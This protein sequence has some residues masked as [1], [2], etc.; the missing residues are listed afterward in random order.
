MTSLF[1]RL[2]QKVSHTRV[3]TAT[4]SRKLRRVARRALL[5]RVGK[6]GPR[7]SLVI[8]PIQQDQRSDHG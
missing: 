3:L 4:R 7:H 2:K 5:E 6:I 1:E 8:D